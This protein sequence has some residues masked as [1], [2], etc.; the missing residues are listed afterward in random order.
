MGKIERMESQIKALQD[1]VGALVTV[2]NMLIDDVF[3]PEFVKKID[4]LVSYGEKE[5]DKGQSA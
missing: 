5:A 3:E 1:T 4:N 2:V